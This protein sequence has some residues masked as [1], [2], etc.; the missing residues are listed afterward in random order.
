MSLGFKGLIKYKV[1]YDCIIHT[2]IYIYVCV[3]VC[4]CMY[5]ILYF[6]CCEKLKFCKADCV[7]YSFHT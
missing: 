6:N 5:F 1:V 3:C 7:W 2:Y 4:V